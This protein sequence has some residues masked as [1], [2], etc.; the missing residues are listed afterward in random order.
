MRSASKSPKN[1]SARQAFVF[2]ALNMSWQLAVVVLVPVVGGVQL[3]KHFGTGYIWTFVGLGLALAGSGA[4]MWRAIKVAN[5]IP[6]PK[7]TEAEKRE[8][9]KKYEAEDNE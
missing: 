1:E 9:R 4:V 5:S 3:D 7:L 2:A 6:V 8:I